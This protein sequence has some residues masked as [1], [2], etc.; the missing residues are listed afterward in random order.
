VGELGFLQ[1][2][3][4]KNHHDLMMKL[5]LIILLCCYLDKIYFLKVLKQFEGSF[6]WWVFFLM[7]TLQVML[8]QLVTTY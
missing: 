8:G 4:A 3:L 7:L 5:C 2:K 6:K 1:L